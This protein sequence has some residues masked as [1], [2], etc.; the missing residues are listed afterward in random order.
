MN[1]K[2]WIPLA[3]A[4]VLGLVAAKVA[5]DML[6]Q[7]SRQTTASKLTEVV[8]AK[9]DIIAGNELTGADLTTGKVSVESVPER[10]FTSAADLIGRVVESPILKGQSILEPDLAPRGTGSGLQAL[11]PSGMRAITIEVNEFSGLGGMITPGSRVDV[12]STVQ[13]NGTDEL[14]ARTV[15]QNV[16]ITA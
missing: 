4:V 7:R 14:L 8:I 1:V 16:K 11:V 13:P 9:R 3:L 5:R 15:V 12:I 6:A 10:S 2:T